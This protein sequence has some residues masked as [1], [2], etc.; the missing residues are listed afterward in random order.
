MWKT[1]II[2]VEKG[3]EAE[4]DFTSTPICKGVYGLNR[5]T[6]RFATKLAGCA[7]LAAVVAL[8]SSPSSSADLG[9]VLDSLRTSSL[10]AARSDNPLLDFDAILGILVE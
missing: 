4:P 2:T 3:Y 6:I 7:L 8:L 9:A 1:S 10:Q 5:Q